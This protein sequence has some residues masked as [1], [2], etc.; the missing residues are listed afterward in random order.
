MK[1]LIKYFC[2]ILT[3]AV[4]TV[5]SGAQGHTASAQSNYDAQ[6][7]VVELLELHAN[8]V[9]GGSGTDETYL[10]ADGKRIWKRDS[11]KGEIHY[12]NNIQPLVFWEYIDITLKEEDD[13]LNG[14]DDTFGKVR[15]RGAE[16]GQNNTPSFSGLT[17][18]FTQDGANYTLVYKVRP[19]TREEIGFNMRLKHSG[20]CLETP[21]PQWTESGAILQQWDCNGNLNQWWRLIPAGDGYY[22]IAGT[23]RNR[24]KCLDLAG[25]SNSNGAYIKQYNCHGKDNQLW[26]LR[27]MGNGYYQIISKHSGK[28]LDI[29]WN[30][31]SKN[32]GQIYQWECYGPT[33][34]NQLWKLTSP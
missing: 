31:V 34:S 27:D 28:C 30:V 18:S 2:L 25:Y 15:I 21:G 26:R 16:Y 13:W 14:G 20:K 4:L 19:A 33:N 29:A 32:G 3:I 22:Q 7:M 6:P 1:R 9:Q 5:L 8:W 11:D 23:F 12:L 10:L 24:Y 17:A